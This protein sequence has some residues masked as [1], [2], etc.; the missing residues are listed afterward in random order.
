MLWRPGPGRQN[1]RRGVTAVSAARKSAPCQAPG[2]YP[3]STIRRVTV[4]SSG[5]AI[6]VLAVI[7]SVMVS[8]SVVEVVFAPHRGHLPT[9]PRRVDL[10]GCYAWIEL[11][12]WEKLRPTSTARSP[13]A[14]LA[15]RSAIN[16]RLSWRAA[17]DG[18]SLM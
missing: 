4:G 1:A 17:L 2:P 8:L 5:V 9:N 10:S 16:P 14:L 13:V 7:V 3:S 18:P 11:A 15:V 12:S 6:V